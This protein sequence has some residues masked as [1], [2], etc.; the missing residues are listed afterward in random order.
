MYTPIV[1][2]RETRM[3]NIQQNTLKR[4]I[5]TARKNPKKYSYNKQESKKRHKAMRTRGNREQIFK[6]ADLISNINNYLV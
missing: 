6:M 1:L 2:P 5:D 3:K 4:T